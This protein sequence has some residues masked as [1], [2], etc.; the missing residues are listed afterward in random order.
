MFTTQQIANWFIARENFDM[1]T[2]NNHEKTTQMRLHK[3]L[4]YAQ[5]Y[6]LAIYDEQLFDDKIVAYTHGPLVLGLF[7]KYSGTKDIE[8]AD[9]LTEKVADDYHD[10]SS[11]EDAFNVLEYV[12]DKY[13]NLTTGQLR[14]Q[15]HKED[16]WKNHE[17]NLSMNEKILPKEMQDYFKKSL[18]T[19][20]K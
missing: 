11:N 6:F 4:Y 5:G 1:L 14:N 18:A 19:V 12:Y 17:S 20:F 3:F 13:N 7:E 9:D 2:D 15:T 8:I 16:P 10:V